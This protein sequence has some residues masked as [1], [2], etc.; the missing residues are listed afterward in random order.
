MNLAHV[1]RYF[2]DVLSGMETRAACIPNL[3]RDEGHWRIPRDGPEKIQFPQNL[4]VVGTVNV[5]ETTYLFSPKV[6]DRANTFEFRVA[7]DALAHTAERPQPAAAGDPALTR[8]LLSIAIDDRWHLTRSTPG[9]AEF[10]EHLRRLHALLTD[11]GFEFGHRVFYEAV[12]FAAMYAGTG[13]ANALTALDLQ[14]MQK[15]LP[16]LH[17]SRR[18]L[19]TTLCAVGHFCHDLTFDSQLGVRDAI[20]RFDPLSAQPLN[21]RL[22]ISFEKV[23]RMT[24]ILRANQFVSFTE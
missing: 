3:K 21:A 9:Q 11:G 17:G 14:V 10:L 22:P 23:A 16:R 4:F 2:A 7:T 15:V 19:E 13:D 1:E 5:D 18:R 8:G 12:R 20:A 6:L 24:R